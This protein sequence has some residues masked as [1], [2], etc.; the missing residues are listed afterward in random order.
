MSI[1]PNFTGI[2]LGKFKKSFGSKDKKIADELFENYEKSLVVVD[3]KRH[4]EVGQEEDR[5]MIE[6]A[7][8]G[9][10]EKAV[11]ME[12]NYPYLMSRLAE[13]Q[14]ERVTTESDGWT[15]YFLEY[16]ENLLEKLEGPGKKMIEYLW[17]GRKLFS[18]GKTGTEYP[19]SYLTKEEI[20]IL[21][22][23][24]EE[25]W[26]TYNDFE[27]APDFKGWLEEFRDKGKDLFLTEG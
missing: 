14:P 5:M 9:G 12:N 4:Y 17:Q 11:E 21:L 7:V 16:L 13:T 3:G 22:K 10:P 19:Y 26:S 1:R 23:D 27:F 25:K 2:D 24:M 8:L 20:A 6:E 15:S 18:E